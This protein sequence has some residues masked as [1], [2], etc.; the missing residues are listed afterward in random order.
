ML[1]V[2]RMQ[3]S[4]RMVHRIMFPVLLLERILF[5]AQPVK[6]I[7][8]QMLQVQRMLFRALLVQSIKVYWCNV[9]PVVQPGYVRATMSEVWRA[10]LLLISTLIR[11]GQSGAAAAAIY[12]HLSR[13]LP[14]MT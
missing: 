14:P 13:K 1:L 2:Q 3:S 5:S 4:E 10:G 6:I 9:Q 8:F 11:R 7:L 12:C